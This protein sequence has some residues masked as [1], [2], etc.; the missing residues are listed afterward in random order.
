M[1]RLLPLLAAL[2]LPVSCTEL[3]EPETPEMFSVSNTRA[4]DEHHQVIY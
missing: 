1:K 4:L 2:L 3:L